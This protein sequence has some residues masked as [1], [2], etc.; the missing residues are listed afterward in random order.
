M[1]RT[2]AYGPNVLIPV[3]K[4]SEESA[5]ETLFFPRLTARTAPGRNEPVDDSLMS[6]KAGIR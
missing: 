4:S 3:M 5:G 2:S 6:L 1:T